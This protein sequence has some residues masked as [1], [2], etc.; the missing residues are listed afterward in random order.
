MLAFGS[1]GELS[2]PEEVLMT[3]DG[4]SEGIREALNGCP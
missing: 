2:A 3:E 4:N 1:L